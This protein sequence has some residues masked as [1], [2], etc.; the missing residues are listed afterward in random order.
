VLA[1]RLQ[2]TRIRLITRAG[3]PAAVR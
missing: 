2:A 1:K 3:S